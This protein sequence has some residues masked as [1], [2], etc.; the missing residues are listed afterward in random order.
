MTASDLDRFARAVSLEYAD[1][2]Y[3]GL[4]FTTL[5]QALDAFVESVQ[6]RVTGTVRL[7][8]FKGDCRI[9]GRQSPHAIETHALETAGPESTFARPRVLK[10]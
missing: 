1:L 8:L 9:V 2:I 10:G 7:K 5:R 6:E 4:W 3:N